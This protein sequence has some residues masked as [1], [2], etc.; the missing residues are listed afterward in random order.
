MSKTE[1]KVSDAADE[2]AAA[3]RR[4]EEAIAALRERLN[5]G[6][7]EDIGAKA[8]DAAAS[9]LSEG[10]ALIAEND[11]LSRGQQELR[12]FAKT[13]PLTALGVAFGIGA[14]FAWLA[15]G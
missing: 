3:L 9:L 4:A 8:V 2:I 10:E 15:R 12:A 14:V 7:L 13:R 6:S 1:T 11:L 5:A